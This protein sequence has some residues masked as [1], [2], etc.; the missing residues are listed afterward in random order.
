MSERIRRAACSFPVTTI[1]PAAEADAPALR[2][3]AVA[4]Y[5]R[6]VPRIG[7]EPAPMTADYLAAAR[8]G[9]AWIATQDGQA[10]GFII[11]IPQPG[12]LLVENVAVLPAAQGRGI[13]ARL[14]ALAEERARSLRLPEVRLYTNEA[15]TENLAYYPPHGYTETHRAHQD[16]FHR[17]YFRKRLDS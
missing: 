17:V 5:Q 16:G 1:R 9:Q 3:I 11:L 4:A 13:G 8:H 6:Y 12:Y 2:S 10:A 15:M 14:L 7:R